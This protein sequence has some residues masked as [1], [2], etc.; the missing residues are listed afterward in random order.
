GCDA[1]AIQTTPVKDGDSYIRNGRKQFITNGPIA[2]VFTVM[3]Y[4]DKSKGYKGMTAFLIEKGAP[5][6]SQ[7]SIHET[8]GCRGAL[9]SELI[10][11]DCRVSAEAV[12]GA[13]GRGFIAAMKILDEGRLLLSSSSIGQAEYLLAMS[14]DQAKQRIQFGRPIGD[15]QAIQWMLADM[16]TEIY[17]A[18]MMLYNAISHYESGARINRQA[19]NCKLFATEMLGRVADRAVQIFGGMGWM[20]ECAVERVYRDARIN[21]IVEGT[22]EIMRMII[23]RDLLAAG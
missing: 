1:R 13:E 16:D 2:D 14:I 15:N 6:F 21:R 8:M 4:T 19:A 5:G 22:S 7:G 20:K 17:A 23:A 3:A 12:L 9:Q 18:K 11:E 10:F